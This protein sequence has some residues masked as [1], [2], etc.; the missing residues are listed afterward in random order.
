MKKSTKTSSRK[1]V[2]RREHIGTL[3]LPELKEVGGAGAE[4]FC[5][6]YQP[7]SCNPPTKDEEIDI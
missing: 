6:C 4:E 3:T 1:L 2:L 5:S 7:R